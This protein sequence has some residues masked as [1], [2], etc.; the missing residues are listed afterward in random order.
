MNTDRTSNLSSPHEYNR[1]NKK[2]VFV[3]SLPTLAK[4]IE[5]RRLDIVKISGNDNKVHKSNSQ[6]RSLSFFPPKNVR[7][8]WVA[9]QK[10]TSVFK[11]SRVVCLKRKDIAKKWYL[12]FCLTDYS[13]SNKYEKTSDSNTRFSSPQKTN[14]HTNHFIH[15]IRG[16]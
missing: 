11:I 12:Y 13:E 7:I 14:F 8:F 1:R 16:F 9:S 5:H 4:L 10:W 3:Q 6:Q 15:R 2:L